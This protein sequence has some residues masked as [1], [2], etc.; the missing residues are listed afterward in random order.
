VLGTLPTRRPFALWRRLLAF[1]GALCLAL[2]ATFGLAGDD[3]EADGTKDAG[4]DAKA[5]IPPDPPALAERVQWVFDLRWDAG[6]VYLLQI[7]KLDMGEVHPTPRM[8]GRFALELFEGP[9]LIERAR[10]DFPMLGPPETADASFM[11]PV[12]LEPRLKTRIGVLFPATKR[13]TR[14]EL[15]D[16]A[17]DR[18]WPLPWP[19]VEGT[20]G[21]PRGDAGR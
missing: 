20:F 15:W 9:T 11:S 7:H 12:R 10:F 2:A 14:L 19:P 5:K 16:R 18:R 6:E 17:T 4:A 8:M 1:A 21:G 3:A 13:G